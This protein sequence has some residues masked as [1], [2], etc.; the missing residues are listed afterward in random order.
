MCNDRTNPVATP[1]RAARQ[2]IN[3]VFH[4]S[5]VARQNELVGDSALKQLSPSYSGDVQNNGAEIMTK[6][7][8]QTNDEQTSDP[9]MLGKMKLFKW[10]DSTYY[11]TDQKTV[12]AKT[13]PVV[14]VNGNQM[15]TE[16]EV[17]MNTK[18]TSDL[19]MLDK[20][21]LYKWL[22]STNYGIDQMTG[23]AKPVPVAAEYGNNAKM[24]NVQ[25]SGAP[26]TTQHSQDNTVDTA[27]DEFPVF[28]I[29]P[30]I[31]CPP[32]NDMPI[33]TIIKAREYQ[34]NKFPGLFDIFNGPLH[35]GSKGTIK[36]Y[37]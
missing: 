17:H 25:L 10:L 5:M 3:A 12:S 9:A 37:L 19:A 18:K 30:P 26:S 14:T 2:A 15:R 22:D 24:T 13:A 36:Q 23:S 21:K 27:P 4:T 31:Y 32:A 11:G 35:K 28:S 33:A 20:M 16:H 34:K 7:E 8:A 1:I 6:T 29:N